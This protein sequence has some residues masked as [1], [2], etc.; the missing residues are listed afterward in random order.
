MFQFGLQIFM[1][2]LEKCYVT[3]IFKIIVHNMFIAF[4]F[5]IGKKF[6]YIFYY[7]ISSMMFVL[8]HLEFSVD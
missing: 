5:T 1:Y 2:T 4:S 3:N 6:S 8:F 7:K